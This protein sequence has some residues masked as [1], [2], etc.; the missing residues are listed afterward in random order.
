MKKHFLFSE[1]RGLILLLVG[2]LLAVS[3]FAQ[4]PTIKGVVKDA[5]LGDPIIGASVLEKGTT[6]GTITDCLR[7]VRQMVRL[8]ISMVISC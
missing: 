3:G 5:K 6:N 1:A 4:S 7:R 2:V 8:P